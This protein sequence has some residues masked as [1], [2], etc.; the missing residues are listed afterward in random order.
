VNE[1]V[2]EWPPSPYRLIRAL[3]D[4]WKRKRPDWDA[5]R[6]ENLLAPL[7][8]CP[9]RFLLPP[10]SVSHTR[11]F[12]SK[13]EEDLTQ[14]TLIFDAFVA[15][16]PRSGVLAA[17][18]EVTLESA[19]VADLDELLSVVNYLGRS[20]SWVSARVLA[21]VI[22]G[23][24]NCLP[25]EPAAEHADMDTVPVACASARE[26]LPAWLEALAFSTADLFEARLSGPPALRFVSY[27]RPR[28]CFAITPLGRTVKNPRPIHGALF[29]LESKVL[30][31]SI[32]TIEIAER[33]R[34][35]LMGIHKRLAG[36]EDLVSPKFSGKDADG[37]S[38]KG[39]RHAFIL[40][41]DQN[42]DGRLD[43]L[44]VVCR[45]PL[46]EL[47]KL[48]LDQM[49][50]LWQADGRP[51]IRCT[52]IQWGNLEQLLPP[53]RR[54][55]SVTPF[56]P[57]RH[58]REGRGDFGEW[59]RAELVRELENHGLQAPATVRSVERAVLRGGQDFRW[60][61]FRRNRR[62]DSPRLGYGFE[63]EFA[64]PVVGPIAVGYGCH[65]GLGQFRAVE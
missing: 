39:H 49:N 64:E 10:A 20:E 41:F 11:S 4:A 29:A 5:H 23:A 38:L 1:G 55:V 32:S 2:P 7:A 15:V 37:K 17:W 22:D 59:L 36:G 48:A 51:D 46:D 50:S 34:S 33:V 65:F 45:E 58:Y 63:V 61:E 62:K 6:V 27:L 8:S 52:P 12:L 44:L 25:E 30:P 35:K 31:Q 47:E 28:R 3:F 24:W 53:S 43:H 9:P 54:L 14:K 42:L 19:A 57:T 40:P 13:N 21:G 60:I 18:P 26:D 16:S 56:V